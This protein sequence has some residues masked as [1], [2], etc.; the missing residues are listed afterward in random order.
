V[1]E[2]GSA[3]RTPDLAALV[4][5]V[6][7]RAGWAQG[8]ALAIQV[9]GTGRRTAEAFEGAASFAPLLHVEYSAGSGGGGDPVNEAPAVQ[10][11]A[12]RSVTLPDTVA[13]DA[14]VTDDGL[15][16]AASLT[17]TWSEVSGPGDVTF[18]P[19]DTEDT[20]ASFSA[21]GSYVL[22]LSVS[23]G[24]LTG[25]DD[26]TVTVNP[27]G[28]GGG[29]TTQRTSVRVAASSDDA[30]QSTKSGSN[31]LAS[32]DL[33]L[34]TDGST[35]QIVGMRFAG[36]EVPQGATVTGAHIQFATDEV[37]T[38]SSSLQIR[39]EASDNA[40]TYRAVS[41]D[42]GARATT[43]HA[44][45]WAPPE[46][47]VLRDA[48]SA[49]RTPD[50]AAL[51]QAVVD[52][53]GW[54][55]GNA[56]AMQ[57]SGT[58]VRKAVSFDGAASLAPLLEVE[59]TTGSGGGGMNRAPVVSAGADQSVTM[60]ST[61]ILDGTVTDDG[62][63]QPPGSVTTAWALVSGPGSVTFLD[64]A[65]ID[66]SAEF[67]EAGTY[68][69]RL[70][71][72][73]GDATATDE[74]TIVLESADGGGS[75]DLPGLIDGIEIESHDHLPP[76]I[77]AN[78]NLYRVTEDYYAKGNYP[79][80]MKSSDGGA[81]WS[82]QDV[83]HHPSKG[84]TEG[85]WVL[86]DGPTIWFAYQTGA[87]VY[88][89][90]FRTSDHPTSP[91]TYEISVETVATPEPPGAQYASLVGNADGSMWVAYGDTP[92][93]GYRSALV[94]REPGGGYGAPIRIENGTAT[95]APRIVKG[96]GDKTHVFYKDDTNN[97]LY[98]RTLTDSGQLS[99]A[100]RVDVSGTHAI[101]TPLTNPV[102][103]DDGGVEV[104]MIAF[105][106]RDGVLR[107]VEIRDGVVGAEEVV[108]GTPVTISPGQT[109]SLAAVAHL[110]VA[111]STVLALWSDGPD[112][113]VYRDLHTAGEA[114]GDDV[115]TV[116]TG[117]G[118]ASQVQYV[119]GNVLALAGSTARVGFTYDM[120]PHPDDDSNIYYDELTI[121]LGSTTGTSNVA[122]LVDA[123]PDQTIT[124]PAAAS[125]D[126][127]VIDDGLPQPP[128]AVLT[129]WSKV[130]GPGEV[131]FGDVAAT[132]TSA[133]FSTAGTYVL[134]LAADDGALS[135]A[136]DVTVVV[137]MPAGGATNQAP[138]VDAGPDQTITLPA[139]ASLD[140][141]VIDDDLPQPPGAVLTTWSKVSGPGEVTF[142]D[143]AATD[144]SAS[145]S[146]AGT[147]VLQLA[148][149]DGALSGADEVT[150]TVQPAPGGATATVEV[151]IS[152][153]WDDVEQSTKSSRSILLA[154]SDLE[155]TTDGRTEQ[156]IGLRFPAL[157][158]PQGATITG[159]W[160]QFTTDEASA[161]ETSLSLRAEDSDDAA[162]YQRLADDVTR[163][164]M[165]DLSVQWSPPPWEIVGEAGIAQRTPDLSAL[166]QA[167]VSRSG[168]TEGNALALQ[169]SGTG[170]RTAVSYDKDPARAPLLHVEYTVG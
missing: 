41:G 16:S 162:P 25:F 98:W 2:T 67:S 8:N 58:G 65:S 62:L 21:E 161:G 38:G 52:R 81:T 71:A 138:L 82:E 33:E 61:V 88:L 73:D 4:E 51:V 19:N 106:D 92:S 160:L 45:A 42:V 121:P 101:D 44:V 105:A 27:T 124:L 83:A 5:A 139:A 15:P 39:A 155:L 127:T 108:S 1:G 36:L 163:R 90:R 102:V 158:L 169:V 111:G 54:A 26:V 118:T 47:T 125:L 116:D 156:V 145:F 91:D 136:D 159:A 76:V 93:G 32:S 59:Y 9:S 50:L 49:Q 149:D 14:T 79:R 150:V 135:A 123:G 13:I 77:D 153:S 165:T 20:T 147:Y 23:D 30:E 60:P 85:G 128:G 57:V 120:G 28:T 140:G 133:S 86:Q 112:G 3:Q 131:T 55:A 78:G 6:V 24:E 34:T 80:M 148:A 87:T 12:D 129:S 143:V 31:L 74:V 104:V 72:D 35:V 40:L 53:Q 113:H 151:K 96:A 109:T 166:V 46:W 152:Q 29:G 64:A 66:T 84:D 68:V 17:Y 43:S 126:G 110:A 114:W 168:W 144:T 164:A 154:S 18:T 69:L 141:T 117:A 170:R 70:S 157:Q 115:V 89:T 142:G 56:I 167:V 22:R 132:D 94:K 134:R 103:Y 146:T 122:P 137:H 75:P 7:G 10:L 11:G 63:P 95:T 119:Y 97:R 130:S 100:V 37:S 48:G 99:P 107:S